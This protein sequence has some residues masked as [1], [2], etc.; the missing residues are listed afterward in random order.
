MSSEN[1]IKL[2]PKH[3][4]AKKVHGLLEKHKDWLFSVRE[5]KNV[6][7][8]EYSEQINTAALS[9]ILLRMSKKRI[10][11]K[12]KKQFDR[13]Y[14]YTLN[15]GLDLDEKYLEFALPY[16]FD[17]KTRLLQEMFKSDFEKLNNNESFPLQ[18]IE[19]LEFV[20]KYGIDCFRD[21]NI[22][23][24]LTVMTGFIMFDGF[25]KWNKESI[26]FCF[27]H[28]EDAS[29]FKNK[30]EGLFP[31]SKMMLK[32]HAFCYNTYVCNKTFAELMSV[33]GAPEGRK[34]N[35]TFFVPNWI[36]NGPDHLK[37]EF[38]SIAIGNEG[39][40]PTLKSRRIQFVSSKCKD[41]VLDLLLFVNQIRALLFHFNIE[42]SPI[43]LRNPGGNR[44]FHARFYIKGKDNLIKFH[45][46]FKF[47][48]ASEKQE[49][50]EALMLKIYKQ[51]QT[52]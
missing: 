47:L 50:L 28:E 8:Q 29:L 6:F 10:L 2:Q 40:A 52:L 7:E 43:Q 30:F 5:F 26:V 35:Q 19:R 27:R 22:Q 12:S 18:N 31:K 20:K 41:K 1:L 16:E 36:Y 14:R 38:I 33:L 49:S 15:E 34:I 24:F 9:T 39:S 37:K 42:T 44:Q 32:Y 46:Q 45:K 4:K 25:I 13:G 17:D 3:S 48:Y 11:F 51:L 23:R 21:E